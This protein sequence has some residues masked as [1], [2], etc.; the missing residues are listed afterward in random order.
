[1]YIILCIKLWCLADDSAN[2][3][4]ACNVK[5]VSSFYKIAKEAIIYENLI[6]IVNYDVLHLRSSVWEPWLRYTQYSMWMTAVNIY[7]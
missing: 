3:W 6:G 7:E 2:L 1:M 5:A 4:T